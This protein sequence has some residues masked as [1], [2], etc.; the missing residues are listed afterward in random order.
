MNTQFTMEP[1]LPQQSETFETLI[2]QAQVLTKAKTRALEL[3]DEAG[4]LAKRIKE[5]EERQ[6]PDLLLAIGLTEI[7]LTSGETIKL[8]TE[9]FGSVSQERMP[10][11]MAWLESRNMQGIAKKQIIIED[12]DEAI[13]KFLEEEGI[14]HIVKT[15]IH[16]ATLKAFVRERLEAKDAEF[17]KEVFSASEV[18][19]AIVIQSK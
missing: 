2:K 19:K 5:L 13:E 6:I 17:P 14:K 16:A 8:K 15:S 18:Q 9:Y 3:F 11:A 1:I 12:F 7:K 4:I 10:Q